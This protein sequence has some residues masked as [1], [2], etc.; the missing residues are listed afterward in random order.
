MLSHKESI[1]NFN[2]DHTEMT[3][4]SPSLKI[5]RGELKDS[6]GK[7]IEGRECTQVIPCKFNIVKL[8]AD[9]P[10]PGQYQ[11]CLFFRD[12]TSNNKW[13]LGVKYVIHTSKG[14]G[15]NR[16]GFPKLGREFYE[17]GF[18]LESP[19]EN[20]LAEQ[21]KATITFHNDNLQISGISADLL[22]F[23]AERKLEEEYDGFLFS[24]CE[25]TNTGYR[26]L[27]HCPFSGE[28]VLNLFAKHFGEGQ[29]DT[30]VCTYHISALSGVGPIPGFPRMSGSFTAWG[31]ELIEP[32]Q[33][34]HVQD[35]RASVKIRA[36]EKVQ[37]Y[38]Q[39]MQGKQHLNDDLCFCKKIDGIC[40]ILVHAPE[41]GRFQ[42]NIF[43]KKSDSQDDKYMASYMIKSDKA[44]GLN[45]GFP[46]LEDDFDEW[47]LELVD[48]SENIVSHDGQVTLTIS[49]PNEVSLMLYLFDMN[50]KQI[51]HNLPADT[52]EMKTVVTCKLPELGRYK[53]GI[54]GTNSRLDSSK[55]VFLGSYKM[56][57]TSS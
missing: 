42:L 4:Y 11:L 37:L 3:F 30:F 26:I 13:H 55:Q 57:H 25:K 8:R 56:L 5:L 6:A 45:P 51:G 47:G 10:A 33:N 46:Y 34:I 44:A 15:K 53:L 49:H 43:G 7:E 29:S 18:H 41:P 19:L 12:I 20:I 38:G 16:G 50:D 1:Y 35:G 31:L 22:I 14:V 39:L 23:G 32:L 9:F 48:H 2:E 52:A 27:V 17:M 40:T 54:F 36:P 21:G 28:Y 24:Y